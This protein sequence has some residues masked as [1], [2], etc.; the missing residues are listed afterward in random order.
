MVVKS[1]IVRLEIR[2]LMC[3]DLRRGKFLFDRVWKVS[4][5]FQIGLKCPESGSSRSDIDD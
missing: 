5:L 2:N 4:K 1:S 3:I